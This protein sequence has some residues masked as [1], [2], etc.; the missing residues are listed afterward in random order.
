MNL[1][2]DVKFVFLT[3]RNDTRLP[4]HYRHGQGESFTCMQITNA[5]YFILWQTVILATVQVMDCHSDRPGRGGWLH[6][7]STVMVCILIAISSW[8]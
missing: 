5:A 1:H 7:Q 8:T 6:G 2:I 3:A 4:F